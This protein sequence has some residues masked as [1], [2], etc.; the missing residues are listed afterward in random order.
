MAVPISHRAPHRK[1]Y[2]RENGLWAS[3]AWA[4]A[5]RAEAEEGGAWFAPGQHDFE[6]SYKRAQ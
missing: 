1:W 6:E 2:Q 3:K 4:E 5:D